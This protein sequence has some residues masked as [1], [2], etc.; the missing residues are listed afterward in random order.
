MATSDSKPYGIVYCVTNLVNGKRYIGQTTMPLARRWSAHCGANVSCRALSAAIRKYGRGHFTIEQIDA[1]T[2]RDQLDKM[3]CL[4]IARFGTMDRALGY[5]LREG[6]N[7]STPSDESRKRMSKAKTGTTMPEAQRM[8]ISAALKGRVKS[9]E[10]NAR[11][12]AAKS[13]KPLSEEH[14]SK[15]SAARMGWVMPDSH[16]EAVSRAAKARHAA[17]KLQAN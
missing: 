13:G 6:G 7:T 3:E 10:H 8:K 2:T 5:N 4:Y 15:L 11:V 12:S 1:A 14:R 16:R 17:A 9:A